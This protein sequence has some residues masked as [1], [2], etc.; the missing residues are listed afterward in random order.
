[1]PH[2]L[3]TDTGRAPATGIDIAAL[4]AA[5]VAP[6]LGLV[7]ALVARSAAKNSGARASGITAAALVVSIVLTGVWSLALVVGGVAASLAL[8]QGL[9]SAPTIGTSTPEPSLVAHRIT[10]HATRPDGAAL[11]DKDFAIV[12]SIIEARLASSGLA[13]N[14]LYRSGDHISVTFGAEADSA[15]VDQAAQLLRVDYRADFR[16][17][18][19]ST[20]CDPSAPQ[21]GAGEQVTLC[22]LDGTEGLVLGP[23]GVTG[24]SITSASADQLTNSAGG[25]LSG[26]AVTV[27]FDQEGAIALRALT[28]QLSGKSQGENRLAIVLDGHVLSAPAVTSSLNDGVIQI[29]GTFTQDEA[30]TLAQQLTDA[31]FGLTLV[32]DSV[33]HVK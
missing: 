12:R 13:N 8:S 31:T 2:D 26:W 5:I 22:T 18:L 29:S 25:P 15:A 33:D 30:E 6:I 21:Q 20:T 14:G 9:A 32:L 11:D 1:M 23:S 7:L 16:P 3:S 17:V 24:Q 28:E 10:L 19:A 27:R 4:V